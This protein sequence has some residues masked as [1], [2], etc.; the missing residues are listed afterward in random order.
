MVEFS[1]I[2]VCLNS[3][4]K[5][6]DTLASV[7]EQS[8]H[9]FEV[10]I[11]DGGSTDTSLELIPKDSRI[12]IYKEPDSGVYDAMNQAVRHTTG[13]YIIFMNCGDYFFDKDVLL[14]VEDVILSQKEPID[15]YY[16]D[17]FV[18]SRKAVIKAPEK[19]DDYCLMTKTICHQSIFWRKQL[20]DA[21]Q[22]NCIE[23]KIAADMELYIRAIKKF[24]AKTYY[25]KLIVADYEGQGISDSIEHKKINYAENEHILMSYFSPSE[26]RRVVRNKILHLQYLKEWISTKKCLSMFYEKSASFIQRWKMR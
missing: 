24:H 22:Y 11:K 4:N 21:C 25:L 10:I 6:V 20:A 13:K 7:L 16:G 23:Y 17:V 8:F 19:L 12:R 2:T 26:R 1:I 5:L 3:G 18:R 14:K 15:I 9:D